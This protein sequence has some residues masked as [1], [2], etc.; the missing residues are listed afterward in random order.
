MDL[1][2][3]DQIVCL[4]N[5]YM[6]LKTQ[7]TIGFYLYQ[8]KVFTLSHLIKILFDSSAKK[9]SSF[10]NELQVSNSLLYLLC[11]FHPMNPKTSADAASKPI[12][13]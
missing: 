10:F 8:L 4:S 3:L 5:K 12:H 7:S 6:I 13:I 11:L 1:G 2:Y 9:K